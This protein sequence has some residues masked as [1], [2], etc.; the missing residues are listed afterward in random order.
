M[1][2]VLTDILTPRLVLI[3]LFCFNRYGQRLGPVQGVGYINELLARLTETPVRDN[4]QTNRTLDSSPI[5][6]PL[7]RTFYADFSHDN[8][9]I[10]AYA[11]MGLFK[12]Q[13]PLDP[14]WF[15]SNDTERTWVTS[16]LTPFNGRMVVERLSCDLSGT[17]GLVVRESPEKEGSGR[18]TFVRILVNDALQ[19]LEFCVGDKDG[20]CALDAFVQSQAYA[21]NDGNGDFEKCFT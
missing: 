18:G 9:M 20:L 7:N 5:T 21:R 10:A 4:T 16:H 3:H 19:P 1:F 11:A 2:P 15:D 8:Q 14:T 13:T 17:A 12:Q 6:F